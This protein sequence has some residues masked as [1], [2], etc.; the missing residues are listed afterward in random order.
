M[1]SGGYTYMLLD[2]GSEKVWAAIIQAPVEVGQKVN[3]INAAMMVGFES[4]TLNR[5]FDRIYFGMLP[6]QGDPGAARPSTR[7]ATSQK[8]PLGSE[9]VEPEAA[10]MAS[11]HSP[12]TAKE[13]LEAPIAKAPG[14]Q[15]RTVAEVHARKSRLERRQ[16]T[17]R[18]KVTKY[19]AG[20]MGRNWL[21]LQDGTGSAKGGDFDLTV[22]TMQ[23]AAVGQ[24]VEI[25]GTV[26]LDKDFGAGYRY[27]V[28][29]EAAVVK[30]VA[31]EEVPVASEQ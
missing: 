4:K 25:T 28:I 27:P 18:G 24:V 14:K 5:K 15:G 31:S 2:T 17:V 20:I 23:E 16:V 11:S 21:H 13:P 10:A 1:N 19:N 8:P 26:G 30:P 3:V 6:S 7:P 29:V 9:A 22:T 12:V